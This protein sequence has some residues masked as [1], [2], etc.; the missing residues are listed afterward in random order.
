MDYVSSGLIRL[1]FFA[2]NYVSSGLIRL[3]VYH[4]IIYVCDFLVNLDEFFVVV[5]TGFHEVVVCTRYV[6]L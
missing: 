5:C 6:S 1:I 3:I 4:H 2:G